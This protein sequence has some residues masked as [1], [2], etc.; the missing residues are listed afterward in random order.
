MCC[1]VA[2]RNLEIVAEENLSENADAVGAYLRARLGEKLHGLDTVGEVR[3]LGLLNGVELIEDSETKTPL[4]DAKMAA[5]VA[6]C[7]QES[8]VFIGRTSFTVPGHGNVLIVAPPLIATE[9]DA[10]VLVDAIAA[11]VEEA[12]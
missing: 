9:D 4:S 12:A 8:G 3:G 6:H 7:L 5:V 10:E 1:A 2:Q 11:A